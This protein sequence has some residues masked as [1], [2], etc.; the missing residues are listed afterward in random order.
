[1]SLSS[2]LGSASSDA[3]PT[4]STGTT[5]SAEASGRVKKR[6]RRT[7]ACDDC[8]RRKV[9]C[10]GNR[11]SCTSCLRHGV[12]CHYQETVKKRGPKPGYI[13]KLERRLNMM[14][15]MLMPLSSSSDDRSPPPINQN[16]P[17]RQRSRS[18]TMDNVNSPTI[19]NNLDWLLQMGNWVGTT[20]I[21][22][23]P[24]NMPLGQL[25][26]MTP[27]TEPLPMAEN[28]ELRDHLVDNFFTYTQ[29]FGG[30]VH[31]NTFLRQIRDGTAPP[32][33]LY[34]I[35]ALGV[36]FSPLP[37][38]RNDPTLRGGMVYIYR[39]KTML[40]NMVTIPDVNSVITLHLVGMYLQ[41]CGDLA[42]S[43]IASGASLRMAQAINLHVLDDESYS[44]PRG[45]S[46]HDSWVD[47]ETKRRI[48][49]SLF[50]VDRLAGLASGR[51]MSIDEQDCN[52]ELP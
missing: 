36:R 19:S 18:S 1:M 32:P 6:S 28:P 4:R 23:A 44:A 15:K 29:S 45:M 38:V 40:K 34:S 5:A 16:P 52:V 7:Q 3:A 43:W 49:W 21:I 50:C 12:A 42:K 37:E 20:P 41:A 48:W 2:P 46:K 9:R 14:E 51:P 22:G 35:M 39:A 25:T 31:R 47:K 13:E 8:R 33:L 10:D 26:D 17:S 24:T 30:I 27:T 11:P